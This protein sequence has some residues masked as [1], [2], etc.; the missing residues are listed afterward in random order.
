M[1]IKRKITYKRT[2]KSNKTNQP[3]FLDKYLSTRVDLVKLPLFR[4]RHA[5]LTRN[6]TFANCIC[7]DCIVRSLISMRVFCNTHIIVRFWIFKIREVLFAESVID[8]ESCKCWGFSFLRDCST[9][10][11]RL[12]YESIITS[13]LVVFFLVVSF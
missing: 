1:I 5:I 10:V 12:F 6:D 3:L 9:T 13:S 7:V 8:R 11:V 4:S 2:N